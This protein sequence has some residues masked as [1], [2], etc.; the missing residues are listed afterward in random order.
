MRDPPGEP[1]E[2]ITMDFIGPLPLSKGNKRILVICDRLTK[3]NIFAAC[4]HDID[5]TELERVF[6]NEVVRHHGIPR[7]ITTD[8]DTLFT[9]THWRNVTKKLGIETEV[10]TAYHQ[11]ANRQSERMIQTLKTYLR[12]YVNQ[13]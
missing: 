13:S 8:R 3:Y 10:I 7:T 5:T 6:L 9:S 11:E 12:H 1:W 4:R 2:E